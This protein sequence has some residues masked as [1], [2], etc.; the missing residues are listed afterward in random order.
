MDM[1]LNEFKY[2][3]STCWNEKYYPLTT[4]MTKDKYQGR[5][6]LGL[7]AIFVP[8]SSPFLKNLI[9]YNH[10]YSNLNCYY[11]SRKKLFFS[12]CY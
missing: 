5:N 3:I 11:T 8:D 6:R 1:T 2:L 9:C 4:D 7:N 12:N 10:S